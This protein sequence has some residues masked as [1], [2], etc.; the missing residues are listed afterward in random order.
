MEHY[1]LQLHDLERA[2]YIDA[3][4]REHEN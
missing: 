2:E 1:P 4:Q 3:K